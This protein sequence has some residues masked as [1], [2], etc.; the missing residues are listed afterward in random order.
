MVAKYLEVILLHSVS[1]LE[2]LWDYRNS[3]CKVSVLK[4]IEKNEILVCSREIQTKSKFRFENCRMSCFMWSS[5]CERRGAPRLQSVWSW[6]VK[7]DG[8]L[9]GDMWLWL[10]LSKVG[11]VARWV[12]WAGLMKRRSK[13]WIFFHASKHHFQPLSKCST[14][15]LV[16]FLAIQIEKSSGKFYCKAISYLA[17]SSLLL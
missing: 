10:N 3:A 4:S 15:A 5:I 12:R 7:H 2:K 13:G 11:D 16:H 1:Q 6:E 8:G 14:L 17:L 9:S